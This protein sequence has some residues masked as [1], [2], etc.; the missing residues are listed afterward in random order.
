[1]EQPL[2]E[3]ERGRGEI[4]VSHFASSAMARCSA[5]CG[6]TTGAWDA[7]IAAMALGSCEWNID[8][9]NCSI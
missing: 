2:G 6:G 3:M 1:M 7:C 9:M 5:S 8:S 4:L